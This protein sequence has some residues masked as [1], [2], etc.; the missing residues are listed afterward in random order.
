MIFAGSL[1][2]PVVTL[3]ESGV[4]SLTAQWSDINKDVSSWL[5]EIAN[6]DTEE[7]KV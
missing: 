6:R 7:I 1:S 5:V 2:T 3:L 4:T